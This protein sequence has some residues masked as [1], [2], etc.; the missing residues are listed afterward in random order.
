MNYRVKNWHAFQH[1]K[2]RKPPWIKLYRSLV[3]VDFDFKRMSHTARGL[4]PFLWLL[5][6]GNDGL[7]LGPDAR[8][9]KDLDWPE[10]EVRNGIKVLV[11]HGFLIPDSTL[12]ASSQQPALLN[13]VNEPAAGPPDCP[14][15]QIVAL[16]HDLLPMC[17]RVRF[18]TEG[19]RRYLRA[20][21]LED[22]K[23]QDLAWWRKFFEHVSRS[24]FL[25]GRTNGSHDRA[26]FIADLEWLVRPS[27]FVKVIEGRYHEATRPH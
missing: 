8:I 22:P 9:A 21:W 6:A 17:P 10:L 14:H 7:I 24:P 15:E 18:W 4:A 13:P 16:Y 2:D 3:T 12:L 19:R 1:Y 25:T 11:E 26:P 23:F 5:A 20:R 27:N